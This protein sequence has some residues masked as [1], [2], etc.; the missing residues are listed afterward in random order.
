MAVSLRGTSEE[1]MG[2][3]LFEEAYTCDA[4]TYSARNQSYLN[5]QKSNTEQ[6]R[7]YKNC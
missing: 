2:C 3:Y 7:D 6:H 4:E 1:C 5:K